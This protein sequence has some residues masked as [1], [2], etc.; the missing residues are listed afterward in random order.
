MNIFF[1]K[2]FTII[3]KIKDSVIKYKKQKKQIIIKYSILILD[4]N[5]NSFKFF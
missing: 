1:L 5:E 3:N 4:K 2:C